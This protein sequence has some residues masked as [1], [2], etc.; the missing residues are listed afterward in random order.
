MALTGTRT[1]VGFG[2][3]AIQSGLFLYEAF[4]SGAF[5]RLVVAEVM[6]DLVSAVRRTGGH[7]FISIAYQDHVEKAQIDSIEIENPAEVSDRQHLIDAIAEADEIGTAVPSVEYYVS[8][9]P[10]SVHCILAAGLCKKVECGGPRAVIY[11]AENNNQAAE[12]LEMR[13]LKHVPEEKREKVRSYVQFLNTVIGKMSRM[14]SDPEEIKTYRLN[15]ITL[16]YPRAFLVESFNKILISKIQFAKPFHRGI[17]VF[18]EK[19][20][21]LPFEEAKLFGHNATHA[22][23]GYIGALRGIRFVADMREIPGCVPF[24]RAAF[25]EESGE[26]LIRKHNGVDPLFTLE[27]YREYADDLLERMMNPF[28][29][30]TIERVTRDTKCKL[31]W[32][33]RLVGTIR[34]ALDLRVKPHRYAFGAAAAMARL[35]RLFL[36]DEISAENML[37]ALWNEASPAKHEKEII[38]NL[39]LNSRRELKDWH[40]SGFPDL[41]AFLKK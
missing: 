28:L 32:N 18:K 35:D 40:D 20:N 11:T 3:G 36:D 12:I 27:G 19:D 8:E 24:M 38:L 10:E 37:D 5:R 6:P 9:K 14:V 30:D 33:D 7:C 41:E 17:T 23:M 13:V 22:L 29:A 1:F 25:I 4:Q 15:T 2:F 34:L 16:D 31:G 21:L 39:I 26:A